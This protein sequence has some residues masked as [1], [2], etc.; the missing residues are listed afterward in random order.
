MGEG[1]PGGA[2]SYA[3]AHV[4]L[5]GEGVVPQLFEVLGSQVFVRVPGHGILTWWMGLKGEILVF[6]KK[7]NTFPNRREGEWGGG[8]CSISG[9]KNS[10]EEPHLIWV[11]MRPSDTF[12]SPAPVTAAAV[13]TATFPCLY[14]FINIWDTTTTTTTHLDPDWL[15]S[16]KQ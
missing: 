16:Q 12:I 8:C 13:A 9:Q 10:S 7:K 5:L 6:T 4:A 15:R 3:E 11:L 14:V 2:G 1:L